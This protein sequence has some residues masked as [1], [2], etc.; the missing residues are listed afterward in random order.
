MCRHTS[1]AAL[2]ALTKNETRFPRWRGTAL[3]RG[4][5]FAV[6]P[7]KLPSGLILHLAALDLLII[8]NQDVSVRTSGYYPGGRYPLPC[9]AP[10]K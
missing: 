9:C 2:L 8:S 4:K 6:A 3:H 5:D 1:Q 10:T 7:R